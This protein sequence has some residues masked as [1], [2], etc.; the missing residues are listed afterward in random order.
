[1]SEEHSEEKEILIQRIENLEKSHSNKLRI[2]GD[3]SL[4]SLGLAGGGT[5]ASLFGATTISLP[6]ITA[7]TGAVTIVAAPAI[8]V[9]GGAVAGGVT[10]YGV[11]K[12]IQNASFNDGQ[13][14]QFLKNEK[15]N[16]EAVNNRER[17]SNLT[18]YDKRK[19]YCFLKKSLKYDVVD[20]NDA[21]E[22]TN[23]LENGSIPLS[24]AYDMI[25]KILSENGV[26]TLERVNYK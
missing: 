17:Q 21:E 15:E 19:F 12:L 14:S 1:M 3:I 23:A 25:E 20:I 8:L 7:L 26:Y 16:L 6:I 2:I 10:L 18:E 13:R 9:A 24:K 11:S 5:A 22:L 4:A